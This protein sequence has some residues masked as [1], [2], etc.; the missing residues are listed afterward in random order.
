MKTI[1]VAVVTTVCPFCGKC[2]D[3]E[4]NEIDYLDWQDGKLAQDA[5][6]QKLSVREVEKLIKNIDKPAK[7]K[8]KDDAE[9]YKLQYEEYAKKLESKLGTKVSISLREKN[10]GKL[11]IDFYSLDDFEK[12]YKTLTD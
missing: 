10:S 9:Q 7:K 6:D 5:F 12:I 1:L 11:E 2:H 8:S 4:V 3:V